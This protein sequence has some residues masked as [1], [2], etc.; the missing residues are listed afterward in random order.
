ML[1]VQPSNTDPEN[2]N[3]PSLSMLIDNYY[4]ARDMGVTTKDKHVIFTV[5][6]AKQTFDNPVS[7]P[8]P[9]KHSV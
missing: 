1:R 2:A 3:V 6:S 4:A 7:S 5:Q 8:A 9:S